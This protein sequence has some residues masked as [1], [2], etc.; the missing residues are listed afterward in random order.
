MMK[1]V[2]QVIE[3]D[4]LEII[5]LLDYDNETNEFRQNKKTLNCA[6]RCI[7][8]LRTFPSSALKVFIGHFNELIN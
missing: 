4:F 1:A 3:S 6:Y 2:T 8:T 7:I 5:K